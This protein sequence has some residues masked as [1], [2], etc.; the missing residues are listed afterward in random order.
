MR[1]PIAVAH[2]LRLE[3]AWP[4]PPIWILSFSMAFSV[5]KKAFNVAKHTG[6]VEK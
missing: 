1:K 3:P 6:N 4:T 2:L 5:A